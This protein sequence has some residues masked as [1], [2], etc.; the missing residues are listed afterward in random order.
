MASATPSGEAT[1]SPLAAAEV[2]M[3]EV[4]VEVEVEV[5]DEGASSASNEEESLDDL[6][7]DD[8]APKKKSAKKKTIKKKVKKLVPVRKN[9]SV[10]EAVSAASSFTPNAASKALV[11]KIN[12]VRTEIN[13][14]LISGGF[15]CFGDRYSRVTGDRRIAEE[16][17]AKLP[18]IQKNSETVDELISSVRAANLVYLT[19]LLCQDLYQNKRDYLPLQ[20]RRAKE[21]EDRKWRQLG[22]DGI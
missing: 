19:E 9:A 18:E 22:L 7:D 15:I 12:K 5:E 21:Q 6:F 14:T 20:Q 13:A 3:R 8:P 10:A 2:E 1:S 4:E 16:L 11:Q 17:L